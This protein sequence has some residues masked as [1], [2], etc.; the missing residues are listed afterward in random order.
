M[1]FLAKMCSPPTCCPIPLLAH[2]SAHV[3]LLPQ[4]LCQDLL[5]IVCHFQ[6]QLVLVVSCVQSLFWFVLSSFPPLQLAE[7]LLVLFSV[8]EFCSCF[9]VTQKALEL[10]KHI[11][12]IQG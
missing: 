7:R 10:V 4:Y 6:I 3:D 5:F 2:I 1:L 11:S 8:G 9:S 12:S